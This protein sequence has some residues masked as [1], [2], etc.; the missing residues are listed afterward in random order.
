MLVFL[1][2]RSLRSLTCVFGGFL[3]LQEAAVKKGEVVRAA[4]KH[5][6][7][8]VLAQEKFVHERESC[9]CKRG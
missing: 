8:K 3:P 7:V 1:K 4:H 6:T 5:V 9:E 2:A